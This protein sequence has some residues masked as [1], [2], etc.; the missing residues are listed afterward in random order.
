MAGGKGKAEGKLTPMMQ[1][2]QSMRRE[3]PDDVLLFFRLGDFYELFFE[4]AKVASPI[5][6]VALTKRNGMP[7]CGV[8]HH[9]AEGYM[10]K[11]IKA[12]KRVA[13]AEQTTEP[14]PGKIVEREIS[15]IISAGTIDDLNLL[16]SARSNYLAAV[17]QTRGTIGFAYIEHTTGEFRVTE[18]KDRDAFEDELHRLRPSELLFS[19]EQA[20]HFD[21]LPNAQDYDGYPF[22]LDQAEYTLKEHF[23]V[24][25][26]DGFGCADLGPAIGAAGAILHYV[27]TQLRRSV[28]HLRTLQA[29]QTDQFV[30][31]DAASQANLDLVTS[32]SGGVKSSLLGAIDRTETPMGARL[33]RNWILHPIRDLDVLVSRQD[34]VESLIRESF[35]LNEL[36]NSFSEIRDIERTLSR[37]SQGSGNA[38]DLKALEMSL[39][40]VPDVREHL[41]AL[42]GGSLGDSLESRL[43]NFEDLVSLL[44]MAIGEE[45]PASLKDGGIFADGYSEAIDELRRAATEGKQWVAELQNAEQDRTGIPSLKIKYNAVFGY[46]IEVTKTHLEKVPPEYTRK[47]TMANAE[48]YITPE[49]KEVENKILGADERLRSL[50][51]EEFLN[52]RETV[53]ESLEAIQTTAAALAEIDVLTAFAEIAR[54]FGYC[55]P[56][57]NESNHLVIEKGRHPVLDQNIG[58][59]KF[60]PNDTAITPEQNRFMLITGPNMAGKSTYIRQVALI[61]LLAQVGSF[62]PATSAEIGLVDRIFTRVGASDDIARGQSTFMVE[63]T[64][65]ALIANNATEK[66]LVILD[67]IGRGTATYDGLS[68]A[69]S[70]VEHLHDRVGCRTLFATHYHE[71]TQLADSR[72]AVNNYNIAVREWNDQIIFLRQIVPGAADKSYGI[73]VARLAGLPDTIID[74]AKEIL[75]GLE[76]EHLPLETEPVSSPP[77]KKTAAK[78][79][80]DEEEEDDP[81]MLLFG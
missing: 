2:Y 61:T 21:L 19:E 58:E 8:P 35:L 34:L 50:E 25:S 44:G 47:Q 10:A 62:V 48:R 64:E 75:A 65:T 20:E 63:M 29:Y 33:L 77:A 15:Q 27:E 32:R 18:F 56:F 43:G 72:A 71:L 66:S 57:L 11:L 60:V 4:D 79:V 78:S 42:Q 74:R 17:Y 45:P 55:R 16:D 23:K 28:G 67:E 37:L 59:E 52:L 1:Q 76:G 12:G 81:Q 36:R 73:Q 80:G 39:R 53:L 3:L 24:Q 6:N 30:L 70:V 13:L 68:I 46:F 54:L 22:L 14:Q 5:L 51:Y 49:L 7:M 41:R 38:R 26:L 9:A 31:I 40:K 69:W